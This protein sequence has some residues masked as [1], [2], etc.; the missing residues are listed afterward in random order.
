VRV[1]SDILG[2]VEECVLAALT[3]YV[4]QKIGYPDYRVESGSLTIV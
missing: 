1:A 4:L 3:D 2:A